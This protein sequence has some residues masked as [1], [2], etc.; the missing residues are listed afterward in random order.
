MFAGNMV[1]PGVD[2]SQQVKPALTL[3]AVLKPGQPDPSS[4]G[5]DSTNPALAPACE[6]EAWDAQTPQPEQQPPEQEV[7]AGA[8]V[9][10]PGG[11]PTPVTAAVE[12]PG[13]VAQPAGPELGEALR[14]INLYRRKHQVSIGLQWHAR[15]MACALI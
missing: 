2:W 14:R 5:S 9:Q 4:L 6:D 15:C 13:D 1:G 12:M 3:A 10:R 7:P 11:A 8:V